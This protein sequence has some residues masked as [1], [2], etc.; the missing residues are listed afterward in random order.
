M[1]YPKPYYIYLRGTIGFPD[2]GLGL[3][4]VVFWSKGSSF[5]CS[6]GRVSRTAGGCAFVMKF[7]FACQESSN[8]S[9]KP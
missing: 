5:P 2:W 3:G 4:L 1:I 8:K 9:P 7:L 6:K